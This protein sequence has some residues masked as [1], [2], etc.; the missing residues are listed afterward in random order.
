MFFLFFFFLLAGMW[1][2][3]FLFPVSLKGRLSLPSFSFLS[4]GESLCRLSVFVCVRFF[5][6]GGGGGLVFLS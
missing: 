2:V 4:L 6:V 1:W 3:I 5:V